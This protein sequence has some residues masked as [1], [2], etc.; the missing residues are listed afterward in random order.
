M[1]LSESVPQSV[2]SSLPS[3]SSAGFYMKETELF[4]I[5]AFARG[6]DI[7]LGVRKICMSTH[8]QANHY[9]NLVPTAPTVNLSAAVYGVISHSIFHQGSI[10]LALQETIIK[11]YRK[12]CIL[13]HSL[14]ANMQKATTYLYI[15]SLKLHSKDWNIHI[16][17]LLRG[18][19][20]NYSFLAWRVCVRHFP[21]WWV[22]ALGRGRCNTQDPVSQ[23]L[24]SN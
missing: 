17:G 3:S 21:V 23:M 24:H 9:G 5:P 6:C 13:S 8:T 12:Y 7:I 2:E 18:M 10:I 19:F 20:N 22:V 15:S 16:W 4:Q 14:P 1:S 11:F